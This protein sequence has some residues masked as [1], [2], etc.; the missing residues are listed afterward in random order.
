M[1]TSYLHPVIQVAESSI[2]EQS[3]QMPQTQTAIDFRA[4]DCS[5]SFMRL[6]RDTL[7]QVEK[8]LLMASNAAVRKLKRGAV[9]GQARAALKRGVWP[10]DEIINAFVECLMNSTNKL[11][12]R[13]TVLAIPTFAFTDDG[14]AT[15]II[16]GVDVDVRQDSAA[17]RHWICAHVLQQHMPK[18]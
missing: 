1:A 13:R 14:K 6:S 18:H 10:D 5:W 2:Q 12:G 9:T 17:M 3:E 15:R 7:V 8:A 16:N 4:V 11:M